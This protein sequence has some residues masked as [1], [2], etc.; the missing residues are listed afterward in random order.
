[1]TKPFFSILLPTK[2]RAHLVGYAIRSVLQQDFQDWELIVC[3]NDDDERATRQVVENLAADSRLIYVRTGNLNMIENWETA[4]SKASGDNIVLLED[5]MIFLPGA[6]GTIREKI[7]QSASGVVVWKCNVIDDCG[8]KAIL[9]V[10]KDTAD[11]IQKSEAV[12]NHLTRDIFSNWTILPRGLC[13]TIPSRLIR[14]IEEAEGR[15]FYEAL[16]PDF[17]SALKVLLHTEAYVVAGAS[18][19]MITSEKVSNGRRNRDR[20]NADTSYMFGTRITP[21]PLDYVSLKNPRVV[22][23]TVVN[24]FR[25]ILARYPAQQSRFPIGHAQYVAMLARELTKASLDTGKLAWSVAE[26]L[27]LIKCEGKFLTNLAILVRVVIVHVAASMRARMLRPVRRE[28]VID[29]VDAFINKIIA[30]K[31]GPSGNP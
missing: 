26:I 18:M 25:K 2:N 10:R 17:T 1:M 24:D 22:V 16:S 30:A 11:L 21:I 14:E 4:L 12:L 13:S 7:A 27:E 6:L 9:R 3:D 15:S 31:T 8:E 20:K 28:V 23:N 5:K 29:D 19:T